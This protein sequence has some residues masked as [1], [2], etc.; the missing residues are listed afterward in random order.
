MLEKALL[1][2]SLVLALSANEFKK[3]DKLV[4]S[5][6]MASVSHPLLHMIETNALSD[7]VDIVDYL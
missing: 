7:V 1:F 6:P 5:G 3:V 4:L 2:L